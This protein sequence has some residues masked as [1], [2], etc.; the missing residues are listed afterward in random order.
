MSANRPS[1]RAVFVE[2]V[3]QQPPGDRERDRVA[4]HHQEI[5]RPALVRKDGEP[6]LEQ[7]RG[8]WRVLVAEG[9]MLRPH[10]RFA[11]VDIG[12]GGAVDTAQKI[13]H[14]T[15]K[16]TR[17]VEHDRALGGFGRT[18]LGRLAEPIG[19]AGNARA[20]VIGGV[21]PDYRHRPP[22]IWPLSAFAR[23][24]RSVFRDVRKV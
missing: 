8:H 9:E 1:K 7:P 13:I 2:M 11:G 5:R 20:R 21:V 18:T 10:G 15:T 12:V 3:A 24:L 4:G 19:E 17:I 23:G 14:S 16:P 6:H 22:R